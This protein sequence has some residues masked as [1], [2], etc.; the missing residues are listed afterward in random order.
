[1][2]AL[3]SVHRGRIAISSAALPAIETVTF[4][5]ED[6]SIVFVASAGSRLAA[7]TN[8]DVVAFQADSEHIAGEPEWT[9][10]VVGVA[11]RV[12]NPIEASR[13]AEGLS[14]SSPW[15]ATDHVVRI[16]ITNLEGKRTIP[17]VGFK[18]AQF[19]REAASR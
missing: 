13:L 12:N 11:G 10:M 4:A 3:H 14:S 6:G 8:D 1:M 5:I 19:N 18:A 17:R 7:A 15:H 16:P 9:V 2:D